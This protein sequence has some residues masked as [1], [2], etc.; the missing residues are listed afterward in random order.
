MGSISGD[1]GSGVLTRSDHGEKW[2]YYLL[3][4]NDSGL[5]SKYLSAKVT[6]Q[7]PAGA[8]YDLY[9]YCASCGGSLA[10]SSSLGGTATEQVNIRWDDTLGTTNDGW[11][12]IEVRYFSG[13]SAA[14]WN[15]QVTGNTVVQSNTCPTP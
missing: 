15:L 12:Y 6:L 11:V 1:T 3:T 13:N 9:V 7:P 14:N 10:G 8:D 5:V 4:E 2:F